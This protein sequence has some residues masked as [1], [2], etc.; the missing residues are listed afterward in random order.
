MLPHREQASSGIRRVKALM[1]DLNDVRVFTVVA[2]R[3]TFSAAGRE[4]RLPTSTVARATTRLEKHLDV[5]LLRRSS[6]GVSL[7]DAGTEFLVSCKQALRTIRIGSETLQE[8]SVNPRGLI[9]VCS[10]IVLANGLLVQILPEFLHKFPEIRIAIETY[11]DDFEQEPRDD[12]DVFF[13]I[14]PPGDSVRRMRKFPSTLRGLFANREYVERVGKPDR[15]DE[16]LAHACIGAKTWQLTNGSSQVTEV[17]PKF[18]VTTSDPVVMCDLVL[19]GLGIAILPLY[20]AR[21]PAIC[22][23]LVPI[24]PRWHPRPAFIS[25]LYFGPHALAPK[26]KLFLDFVGEFLGT[27]RDPRVKEAPFKGLFGKPNAA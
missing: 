22:P 1:L 12:V 27:D 17:A 15:P 16:L 23:Q 5:L 18:R 13:K 10:P 2:R 26:I 7:T 4:L 11:T 19:R 3:G 21:Q 6:K 8:R 20:M 24:L 9:R 14:V 25:A